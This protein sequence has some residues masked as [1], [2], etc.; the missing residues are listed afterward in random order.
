MSYS[1]SYYFVKKPQNCRVSQV[2]GMIH[3][4]RGY[5]DVMRYEEP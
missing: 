3:L 4:S 5:R 2:N 1:R